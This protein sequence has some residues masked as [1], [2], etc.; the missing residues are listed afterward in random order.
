MNATQGSYHVAEF[1]THLESEIRRLDAQV[2]LFWRSERDLLKRF[3]LQDGMHVLDCGCGPGRLLELLEA[4]FN[5]LSLTGLEIDPI[6]VD[7]CRRRFE[8]D[9][10]TRV[11]VQHGSAEEHGLEIG[12]YDF[13][14]MRLVLEHIPDPLAALRSLATLLKPN[15]RL[16]VISNDFAFHL[17]SW[18][19]VPE[20]DPLYEAYCASRERDGG[21]PCLGRRLPVLLS[22]AGLEVVGFEVEVAHSQL[23]GDDAFFQAEG[24]GI[25]AQLVESGFLDQKVFEDMI[26]SWKGMLRNS[27]HCMMR[28]LFVGAG[29]RREENEESESLR[30]KTA[31]GSSADRPTTRVTDQDLVAPSSELE[32]QL[33]DLWRLAM[34]VDDVGIRNNFFDLGGDSLMLEELQAAMAQTMDL[35][36]P[37]AVLFQ[38]PTIE[39][40]AA[41]VERSGDLDPTDRSKAESEGEGESRSEA[42]PKSGESLD[43]KAERRRA[44][45]SN[46]KNRRMDRS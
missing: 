24:V 46:K 43:T 35:H 14:T 45:L 1:S 31:D 12:Q 10:R 25:P 30:E 27:D 41:H 13:I 39:Q 6:L 3:G 2:D 8:S 29:R 18:P 44:A 21:D 22:Q 28:P 9:D 42:E 26:H 15:G 32:R 17:R 19:N 11:R 36:L 4:E 5:G 7:V 23:V 34:D 37:M 33:A 38:Y 16:V 20:L 40:L